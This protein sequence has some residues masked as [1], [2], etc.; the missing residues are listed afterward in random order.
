MTSVVSASIVGLI[1]FI[2][3]VSAFFFTKNKR[4][5]GPW[6]TATLGLMVGSSGAIALHIVYRGSAIVMTDDFVTH[7]Y[8]AIAFLVTIGLWLLTGILLGV[9][10]RANEEQVR[11]ARLQEIRN[12]PPFKDFYPKTQ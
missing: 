12:S 7:W 4:S 11:T 5:F 1:S 3:M 6:L 10:K 9:N 2:L 8:V